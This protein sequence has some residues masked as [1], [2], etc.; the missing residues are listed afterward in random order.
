MR[1]I[2]LQVHVYRPSPI[3]DLRKSH[4]LQ[5]RE[6]GGSNSKGARAR[7]DPEV[8]LGLASAVRI[9]TA[10]K[11]RNDRYTSQWGDHV[12]RQLLQGMNSTAFTNSGSEF[13]N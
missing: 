2:F 12:V 3:F 8:R 13:D 7:H 11:F 4:G 6:L 9:C 10:L 1:Q 5:R